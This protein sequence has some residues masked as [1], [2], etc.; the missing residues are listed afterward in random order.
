MCSV[1]TICLFRNLGVAWIGVSD[2]ASEGSWVNV[3]NSAVVSYTNW[4]TNEPNGNQRE[5]C[6]MM[7]QNTGKWNDARCSATLKYVCKRYIQG[8]DLSHGSIFPNC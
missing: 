8:Y 6:V 7:Y 3:D 4:N 1:I 2:T 5:N